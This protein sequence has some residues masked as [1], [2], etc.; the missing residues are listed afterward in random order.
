MTSIQTPPPHTGRARSR[1]SHMFIMSV[2]LCLLFIVI[3][4]ALSKPLED[5]VEYWTVSR[6]LLAHHNPYSLPE[7]FQIQKSLGWHQPV[8]LVPLN[9]PWALPLFAP[10]AL[11]R[12]YALGW[13]LWVALLACMVAVSS[14]FL[15]DLYF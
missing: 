7:V 8:P 12:S 3:A 9:P 13:I 4:Y 6:L 2:A 14:R 11:A 15:M 1:S 5:F 10:L